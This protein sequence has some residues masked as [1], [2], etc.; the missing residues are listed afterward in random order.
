MERKD[1]V[2]HFA[3]I[4]DAAY[5]GVRDLAGNADF[6]AKAFEPLAVSH[7]LGEEFQSDLLA[8]AEVVGAVD[9]AHATASQQGDDA[10]AVGD[11]GSGKEAALTGKSLKGRPRRWSV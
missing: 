6:V 11:E 10:V 4:E 1:L 7:G 2:R 8:Q 5:V 3:E 9:L